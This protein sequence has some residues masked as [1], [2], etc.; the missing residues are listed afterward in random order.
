[1]IAPETEDGFVQAI[2]AAAANRAPLAL[3]G[4]GSKSGFLRPVQAAETLSTRNFVGTPLYAPTELVITS[5]AGTRLSDLEATLAEAGQHLA[6]EPPSYGFLTDPDDAT[7]AQTVGGI[8]ACN[9]SGPRRIASGATRDYVLGIRV[10]TGTGTK[11]RSGG[12]VLKNVTG[13][14]LCKLITGSYGTLG[15]ITEV[16]LKVLPIP[17]ATSTIVLHNLDAAQGVAAMTTALTSPFSVTG[18]TFLPLEAATY[19]GFHSTATL[20]RVEHYAEFV[21]YQIGKLRSLLNEYGAPDVIDTT[22]SRKV[23]TEIRNAR[24]LVIRPHF[25]IWRVSIPPSRGAKFYMECQKAALHGYLDWGGGLA[26]L[27]GPGNQATHLAVM[28]LAS[29]AD[30]VWWLLRAPDSLRELVTTIP[31]EDHPLAAIRRRL[32]QEFDPAGILN[33]GKMHSV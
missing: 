27:S 32:V 18:A 30:G 24:P 22:E 29:A 12:R 1:M 25:A 14:D 15:L 10:I 5:R 23:W 8:V 33:P 31:R 21:G 6:A 13:L 2:T 16:T 3:E 7:P 20:I 9:L 26:F 11:I 4:L 28:E 17:E 19:L